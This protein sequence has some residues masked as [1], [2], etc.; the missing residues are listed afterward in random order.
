MQNRLQTVSGQEMYSPET[1][2]NQMYALA[3]N[4]DE[5]AL[6]VFLALQNCSINMPWN[7]HTPG[8]LLAFE[9]HHEAAILLA[10]RFGANIHTIV[11]GAALG[12]HVAQV[13]YWLKQGA[14]RG[15]AICGFIQAG[16]QKEA[17][18]LLEAAIADEKYDVLLQAV[19]GHSF[20]GSLENIQ[21]IYKRAKKLDWDNKELLPDYAVW[22][23][24]VQGRADLVNDLINPILCKTSLKARNY[25]VSAYAQSGFHD[26]IN[27]I[28]A[29]FEGKITP[30]YLP[31]MA[32]GYAI[33]G[34]KK[35]V[36][37]VQLA[38]KATRY[39]ASFFMEVLR[40]Y[41]AGCHTVW[42]EDLLKQHDHHKDHICYTLAE[43]NHFAQMENMLSRGASIAKAARGLLKGNAFI[44]P[45]IS[46]RTLSFIQNNDYRIAIAK[47]V[48]KAAKKAARN[49]GKKIAFNILPLLTQAKVIHHL[50]TYE[51][52]TY[53]ESLHRA[54]LSS[55]QSKA[56]AQLSMRIWLLQGIQL[57]KC[58]KL[59]HDLFFMITNLMTPLTPQETGELIIKANL[60]VKAFTKH[61]QLTLFS[62]KIASSPI[63]E[64]SI[65]PGKEKAD[66]KQYG[67]GR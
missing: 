1:V 54:E 21:R 61:N 35:K 29:D 33:S 65:H 26:L 20:A 19:K 14:S 47:E 36:E 4:L 63:L 27:P 51:H 15:H 9:G 30:F 5:N 3:K 39:Y 55:N 49:S 8:S 6:R 11:Y 34:N 2:F 42:L 43:N 58:G 31:D 25:V 48:D 22:A 32:L 53:T 44:N 7:L 24:A 46:L 56:I 17:D 38:I 52:L 57:V 37:E 64:M 60:Y 59:S 10:D 66:G 13:A 28:I 50:M 18:D 23:A 45:A 62:Q 12:R 67:I 41:A 40:G 16:L